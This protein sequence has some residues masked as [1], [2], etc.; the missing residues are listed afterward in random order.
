MSG[1]GTATA[2]MRVEITTEGREA[3]ERLAESVIEAGL[4]ACAQVGGPIL[5]FY[6][7]QGRVCRDEEWTLVCK[8]SADRLAELTAHVVREHSYDVPEVVAVPI[9]GGN[10][11]YLDWVTA[12]TRARP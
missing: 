6:R 7:W 9:S 3:A 4:A 10:P 8:T 12:E 1:S 5:S 11:D 2:P